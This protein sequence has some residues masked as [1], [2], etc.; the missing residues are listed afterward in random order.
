MKKNTLS[1][2]LLA[3]LLGLAACETKDITP[4]PN[5]QGN[6]TSTNP[7]N[8]TGSTLPTVTVQGTSDPTAGITTNTTWTANNKYLLKGFVYV[9]SGA[10]LT[11]EPGTII[12]GDKDTKGALIIEPG[13]KIMAM[14]TAAKP[15]VFTSSQPKGSRNYGD[16]GGVIITGNA[17][18]NT[19]TGRQLAE[20][21]VKTNYGGTNA[22]DNSGVFQYVRIEFAGVAFTPNNEVNGLTLGG[23]GS[24]TTIDHVQV[25]YSGDDSFEWFGGTVNAKYLVSLRCFD[26]DFDTDLGFVGKV[27]Y[28]VSLRDPLQADQSGSKAFESDNDDKAS[29][30]QPQTAPVFSNMTLVGPVLNPSAPN[31]SPQY[32]AGVHIRR[33]SALSLFNSVIM[34]YPT[35]LLIDGNPT[36]TNIAAGTAKVKNNI[37]AGSLTGSNSVAGQRSIISIAGQSGGGGSLTTNNVMASDSSSWGAAIGPLTW[38]KASGNRRYTTS[39]NVQLLNPFNLTAP[40]FQP[41]TGSPIIVVPPATAP[42]IAPDFTDAKVSD[43]FFTKAA[44]IGAFDGSTNW[45]TGWTNFDPQNTDY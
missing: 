38:L 25:S 42:V 36:A 12:L 27:Q 39:D 4:A 24:G 31:Y 17:P 20:G 32:T 45:L 5:L 7:T 22:A 40:S 35:N 34:G 44:H 10:T 16:W 9:T 28:G 1:V 43:S 18:V 37:L 41:R 30:N 14:G 33:N 2:A 6:G 23:V 13:A 19:T 3:T 21:G 8:P 15:I 26:D 11:I 29:T